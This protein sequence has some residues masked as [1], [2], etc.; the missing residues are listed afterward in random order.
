MKISNI[1]ES[2]KTIYSFSSF[3]VR[4]LRCCKVNLL[5]RY[6]FYCFFYLLIFEKIWLP[7]RKRL[8][9][10]WI[11]LGVLCTLFPNPSEQYEYYNSLY[12]TIYD[13]L[14][15]VGLYFCVKEFIFWCDII[16]KNEKLKK[17]LQPKKMVWKID[18]G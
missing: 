13:I 4:S 10:F 3:T 7:S 5:R 14:T 17:C 11:R 1:W 12:N 9:G 6:S 16:K 8:F 18:V 2:Q 15:S